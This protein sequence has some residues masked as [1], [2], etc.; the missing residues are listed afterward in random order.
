ML[1]AIESYTIANATDYTELRDQFIERIKD[2]EK[3][4]KLKTTSFIFRAYPMVLAIMRAELSM[5]LMLREAA[6]AQGL[7]EDF[8]RDRV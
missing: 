7:E 4:S 5:P 3:N 1:S 2:N 8:W 6:I